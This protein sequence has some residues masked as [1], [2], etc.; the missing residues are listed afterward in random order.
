MR[1]QSNNHYSTI[2]ITIMIRR[3]LLTNIKKMYPHLELPSN[4]Q[5]YCV[6][7]KPLGLWEPFIHGL[8]GRPRSQSASLD[9]ASIW[10]SGWTILMRNIVINHDRP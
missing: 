2:I 5:I 4:M 7:A 6:T 9:K 3:I 1:L 10:A 8:N